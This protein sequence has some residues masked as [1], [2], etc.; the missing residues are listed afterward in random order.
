MVKYHTS[1][2][3]DPHELD[4]LKVAHRTLFTHIL[5]IRPPCLEPAFEL[6][7]KN[8][9][10]VPVQIILPEI[11][12]GHPASAQLEAFIDMEAC[13]VLAE[14]DLKV[15]NPDALYEPVKWPISLDRF[16]NAIVV[17]NHDA[18]K[19]LHEVVEISDAINLSST[20]INPD[21]APTYMSYF[22]KKHPEIIFKDDKQPALICKFLGTSSSYFQLLTSRF[23][24]AA[25][26]DIKKSDKR[27][28][29]HELFPEICSFYP[30]PT[31][32]WK[33]TRS[34][35]S[36]LWRIEGFL[37]VDHLRLKILHETRIGHCLDGS[38][39]TTCIKLT[40]YRDI[41]VGQLKSQRY[42]PGF[43]LE[44]ADMLAYFECKPWEEPLRGPD[45]ALLL[46]ALTTKSALDCINLER[47]ETLG[48]CFLKFATTVSLY[49]NRPNSHEGLLSNAR[50]RLVG[51]FNLFFKSKKKKIPCFMLSK[52]FDPR[53]MWIPPGFEF[54]KD[55]AEYPDSLSSLPNEDNFGSD[56]IPE[57]ERNYLYH[58]LSDKSVA[59]SV[60]S[61]IGAYLVSGGILAGL[62]FMDWIGINILS[63]AKRSG[64][65]GKQLS[66]E[67]FGQLDSEYFLSNDF[68]S[69]LKV[70]PQKSHFAK[71]THLKER[72][73]DLPAECEPLLICHSSTILRDFFNPDLKLWHMDYTREENVELDRLLH[74]ALAEK[75]M[76]Q[77][78]GWKFR[79]RWLLLQALTHASYT[80]N[81][82]TDSYQRL[83][84]LGDA[85][86]DYLV[87]CHIYKR[88][89]DYSPGQISCM[90]SALVNNISFAELT[91]QLRLHSFL[92]HA[93]PSLMTN[94]NIF[95]E[96]Y[97]SH[98]ADGDEIFYESSFL[99]PDVSYLNFF[100]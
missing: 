24:Q 72:H 96:N 70:T 9:L 93:S 78:V 95:L 20:F 11:I 34:L 51:N 66:S 12:D 82:L 19:R 90:R 47:L 99:S 63:P 79:N 43:D 89:P 31:N 8:Y 16:R 29:T 10:V 68:T 97:F 87:T 41:G 80:R 35:P 14:F 45:N 50:S 92:L 100:A 94:V 7:K 17:T 13:Q 4:L 23:K 60:E 2:S 61:M 42:L 49:C 27:G 86:L 36:V 28:R 65:G 15:S 57:F 83:E 75:K 67:V 52:T 53:L 44:Q 77:V 55:E 40:G 56:L 6:A 81:R 62:R 22:K 26:K 71:P 37:T 5:C 91:V 39:L 59:D 3:L 76:E 38:E 73:S 25:G 46:Q 58:K 69:K 1:I 88:F 32:L 84:F 64:N 74:I 33:L 21:V 48:D 98:A 85:V 54:V 30:I 18:K